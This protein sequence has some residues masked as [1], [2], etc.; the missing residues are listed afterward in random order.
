MP[1]EVANADNKQG[2]EDGL[3][4]PSQPGRQIDIEVVAAFVG[5]AGR[6]VGEGAGAPVEGQRS[7]FQKHKRRQQSGPARLVPGDHDRN[8]DDAT[9][10]ERPDSGVEELDAHQFA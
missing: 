1:K 8:C 2:S 6:Y 9:G 7:A 10:E 4:V 3:V 5:I